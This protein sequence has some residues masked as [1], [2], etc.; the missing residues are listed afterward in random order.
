MP[1]PLGETDHIVLFLDCIRHRQALL[2]KTGD[3]AA[4]KD[5]TSGNIATFQST[6]TD[7]R[8][9]LEP[10]FIH[11]LDR[12]PHQDDRLFLPPRAAHLTNKKAA[13]L[14]G[15]TQTIYQV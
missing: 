12:R 4:S 1:N 9:E 14:L 2:H 15:T 3:F 10:G 11:P 13:L 7:R 8:L 6:N 5:P